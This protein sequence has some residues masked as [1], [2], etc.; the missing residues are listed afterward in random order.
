M[1]FLIMKTILTTKG[2][3]RTLRKANFV[4]SKLFESLLTRKFKYF[5][6]KA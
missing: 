5:T 3:F 4:N 2:A 6:I 1:N